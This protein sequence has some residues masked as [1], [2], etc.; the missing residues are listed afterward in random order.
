MPAREGLLLSRAKIVHDIGHAR[1]V[2]HRA[3]LQQAELDLEFSEVRAPRPGRV[4]DRRVDA[5]NLVQQGQTPM[6][7]LLALDPVYAIFDSSE[8][9]HLRLAQ[10]TEP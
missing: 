6:T 7:T 2:R 8:A 1:D 3:A 9:Q 4:S 5:G 10:S